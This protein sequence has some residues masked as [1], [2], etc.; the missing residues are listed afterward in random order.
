VTLVLVFAAGVV[1]GGLVVWLAGRPG[2]ELY[3]TQLNESEAQKARLIALSTRNPAVSAQILQPE[4]NI[5]QRYPTDDDENV[6][7]LHDDF[8]FVVDPQPSDAA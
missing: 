6:R 2:F 7:Y 8:G 4:W 3:R 1:L 5:T